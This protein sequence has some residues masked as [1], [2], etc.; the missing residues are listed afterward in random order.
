MKKSKN[1][2]LAASLMGVVSIFGVASQEVK[3]NEV[4]SSADVTLS[5]GIRLTEVPN[6]DF[7]TVIYNGDATS[8]ILSGANLG[9]KKVSWFDGTPTNEHAKIYASI[10]DIPQEGLSE[11]T[12]ELVIG[13]SGSVP[14]VNGTAIESYSWFLGGNKT[15]TF[16]G[17]KN[18]ILNTKNVSS[19]KYAGYSYMKETNKNFSSGAI[20]RKTIKLPAGLQSENMT[21]TVNWDIESSPE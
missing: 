16:N 15:I 18:L 8:Y 6:F 10:S 3:A 4:E 1:L 17:A 14:S 21:M 19:N 11:A 7:G 12:L 2:L 5:Q 20:T 9:D 13:Y